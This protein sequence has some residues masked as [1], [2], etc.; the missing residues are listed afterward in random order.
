MLFT[1]ARLARR[2]FFPQHR[3]VK[4]KSLPRF[5]LQTKRRDPRQMAFR[6]TPRRIWVR[7][8]PPLLRSALSIA[9][10]SASPSLSPKM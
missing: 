10:V 7:L 6:A 2:T 9:S 8:I 1:S 5:L 4:R 3:P